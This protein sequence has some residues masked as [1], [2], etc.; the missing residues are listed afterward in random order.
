MPTI[1]KMSA[2]LSLNQR[3]FSKGLDRATKNLKRFATKVARTGLKVAS[4]GG[5]LATALAGGGLLLLIKQQ[6][7][8]I[9]EMAK[10]SDVTGITTEELA[11]LHLA[12]QITGTE[13]QTMNKALQIFVRRLGEAKQGLGEGLRAFEN[14]GLDAHRLAFMS[15]GDALKIMV[16]EISKLP[17]KADRAAAAYQTFGRQG[18][19]LLNFLELGADGIDEF[20]N[21][22]DKLGLAFSRREAFHVEQFNDSLKRM[23]M[24]FVGIA[25]TIAKFVA[26]WVWT[27]TESLREWI[28]TFDFSGKV[29]GFFNNLATGLAT[30]LNW[31]S[32]LKVGW[33]ELKVKALDSMTAIIDAFQS[34]S[35]KLVNAQSGLATIIMKRAVREKFG[36][37]APEWVKEFFTVLD[38]NVQADQKQRQK[39]Q[40]T[41]ALD[42]LKANLTEARDELVKQQEALEAAMITRQAD[43]QIHFDEWAKAWENVA[44]AAAKARKKWDENLI[45][46]QKEEDQ[47]FRS[48]AQ[49]SRRH[50]AL[51]GLSRVQKVPIVADPEEIAL[52]KRVA[53]N[54]ALTGKAA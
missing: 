7:K 29:A 1:A 45:G 11:G 39:S 21:E 27:L 15:T 5:A 46:Q 13:T 40:S 54:T 35:E 25:R 31:V 24:V 3:A 23:Q 43:I 2:S 53:R 16:E 51:G 49:I 34:M 33:I 10:L 52:L 26:P 9:D 12:A 28:Q 47:K 38:K 17:T 44:D 30:V 18:V 41:P 4:I 20:V 14:F 37:H 42:M 32:A 50:T 36:E 48:F 6:M 19:E 22:A 8:A